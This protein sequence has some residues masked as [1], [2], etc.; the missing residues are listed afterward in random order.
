MPVLFFVVACVFRL[1][2]Q[3]QLGEFPANLKTPLTAGTNEFG[4]WASY[5]PNSFVFDGTSR[6]RKLF[7]A[8]LQ[9]A[10]ILLARRTMAL[11]YTLDVIPL[12]LQKQ[13]TQIYMVNGKPLRNPAATIYGAGASPIGFQLNF[14]SRRVEPFLSGSVGFLYFARQ[15]PV[16][17]SSR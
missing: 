5:S 14:G 9:Y 1:M 7:L 10:R 13:P 2:A 8:N 4:I 6:N 12:A 3:A 16:V 11:K 15:V 17:G